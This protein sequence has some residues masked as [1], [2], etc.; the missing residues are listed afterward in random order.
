MFYAP[1]KYNTFGLLMIYT[2]IHMLD[3]ALHI[4]DTYEKYY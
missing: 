3:F 4:W 1:L 2:Y